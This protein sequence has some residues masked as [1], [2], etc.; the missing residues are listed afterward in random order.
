MDTAVIKTSYNGFPVELHI[1]FEDDD[2]NLQHII[3]MIDLAKSKG[4]TAPVSYNRTGDDQLGQSGTVQG[5]TKGEK[6]K[7]GLQMY[8]VQGMLESG[9]EFSWNEFT[10]T[11]FRK[12]DRFKVVKNDRGFKIGEIILPEPEGGAGEDIP[13]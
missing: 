3:S 1:E 2:F 12:G 8:I 5:V 7:T 13:F 6:T 11:A 10:A 4:F 9:K